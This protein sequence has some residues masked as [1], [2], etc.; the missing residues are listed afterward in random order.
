LP[1]LPRIQTR[2]RARRAFRRC[3]RS[4]ISDEPPVD[5]RR[6]ASVRHR[7]RAGTLKSSLRQPVASGD[8]Y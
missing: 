2:N 4:V 8:P 3:A 1:F 5:P 6:E 7:A